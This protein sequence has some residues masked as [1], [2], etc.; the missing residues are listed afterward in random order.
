MVKLL[1][2][3]PATAIVTLS[4]YYTQLHFQ[5][6]RFVDQNRITPM[7]LQVMNIYLFIFYF[8]GAKMLF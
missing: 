6:V 7:Q 5:N 2:L 4:R 8:W 1:R 3:Q